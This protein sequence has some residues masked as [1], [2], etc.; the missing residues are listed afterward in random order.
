MPP[1]SAE[2]PLHQLAG[3]RVV[4]PHAEVRVGEEDGAVGRL[5]HA[6]E[7]PLRA[8]HDA[9]LQLLLEDVKRNGLKKEASATWDDICIGT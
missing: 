4:L 2:D 6:V 5:A 8:Q 1:A 3:P 9:D 7:A